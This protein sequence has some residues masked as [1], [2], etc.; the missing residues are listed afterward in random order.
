MIYKT[1]SCDFKEKYNLRVTGEI[2][3]TL[4]IESD[5]HQKRARLYLR[6]L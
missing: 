2:R 1:T 4:Q 6:G 3:K 5:W